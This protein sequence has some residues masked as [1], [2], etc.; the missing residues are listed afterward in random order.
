MQ[1]AKP[2]RPLTPQMQAEVDALVFSPPKPALASKNGSKKL[3]HASS[4]VEFVRSRDVVYGHEGGDSKDHFVPGKMLLDDGATHKV[5]GVEE[6]PFDR[7]F[8]HGHDGEDTRDHFI[9]PGAMVLA[10]GATRKVDGVEE[11]AFDRVFDHRHDGE[12]TR[13]H[14]ISPAN[15][16]L[17]PS[18][19]EMGDEL[20]LKEKLD[21]Y[22]HDKQ[23]MQERID[24][25]FESKHMG[26]QQLD[27]LDHFDSVS[28]MTIA[29]DA[30]SCDTP[31]D[32]VYSSA[33]VNEDTR[34]HFAGGGMLMGEDADTEMP[35][36]RIYDSRFDGVR[37]ADHFVGG[38]AGMELEKGSSHANILDP[39]RPD[40]KKN[41]DLHPPFRPKFLHSPSPTKPPKPLTPTKPPSPSLAMQMHL[42]SIVTKG[43]TPPG[44]GGSGGGGGGGGGAALRTSA[45]LGSLPSNDFRWGSDR[46]AHE[47]VSKFEQ[48]TRRREDSMRKLLWTF[49]TDPEFE[50]REPNA[51]KPKNSIAVTPSNF[52]RL[53]HRFGLEC[54]SRQAVEIFEKHKLPPQGCGISHL[55][56]KLFDSPVDTAQLVRDQSRRPLASETARTLPRPRTPIIRKDPFRVAKLPGLTWN[57]H[58]T[59]SLPAL[60]TTPP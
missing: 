20:R 50:V 57:E 26:N 35:F 40:V 33:H 56:S 2:P 49:G 18:V 36:D 47:L 60:S 32:P 48:F 34:D 5:D 28:G 15:M 27:S 52:P 19:N 31:F 16:V 54:D 46:I 37:Q 23:V 42:E 58:H 51:P 41:R 22:E 21:K 24:H 3:S 17:Q 7:V 29:A 4:A 9:S 14:F 43:P 44:S 12:D 11:L 6:L 38:V 8:G 53:C 59:R 45:S 55:S 25:A 30:P 39:L 10:D 13:D 1:P